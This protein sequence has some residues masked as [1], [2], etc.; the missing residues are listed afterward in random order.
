MYQDFEEVVIKELV[1]ITFVQG[2]P[3]KLTT[4]RAARRILTA[5][6]KEV[7]LR[8]LVA[9]LKAAQQVREAETKLFLALEEIR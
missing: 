5:A 7:Y 6:G 4:I 9:A 3:V 8:P 1:S 2:E